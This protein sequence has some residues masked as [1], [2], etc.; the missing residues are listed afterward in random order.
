MKA[1]EIVATIERNLAELRSRVYALERVISSLVATHPD[2]LAFAD[3][4]EN[5]VEM[6][7]ALHLND[8]LV[9]DEVRERQRQVALE[10]AALARDYVDRAGARSQ[11]SG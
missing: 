7:T 1:T 11:V 2:K 6:V 9:T 8:E 10:Y 4:L 5:V 3:N